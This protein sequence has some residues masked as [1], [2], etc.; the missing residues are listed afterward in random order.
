MC[1]VCNIKTYV[2]ETYHKINYRSSR[3][4][5]IIGNQADTRDGQKNKNNNKLTKWN[6]V[7]SLRLIKLLLVR[8]NNFKFAT[9]NSIHP[10]IFKPSEGER[11]SAKRRRRKRNWTSFYLWCSFDVEFSLNLVELFNDRC[12]YVCVSQIIW[13]GF[14]NRKKKYF[15]F[16]KRWPDINSKAP[17]CSAWHA[18]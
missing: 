12:I 18:F 3:K 16:D 6:V 8:L 9:N 1:I 15:L 17:L 5:I 10:L 11:E 7:F 4:L 14:W 2:Y 13:Y